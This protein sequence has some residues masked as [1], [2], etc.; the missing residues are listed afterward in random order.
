[1]E[2]SRLARMA[3]AAESSIVTCSLA[4]TT[5]MGSD[6]TS[7]CWAS[8]RR[9]TSSRPTRM[10]FTPRVL[11]ARIAPSISG[12]GAWSVPMASTAIVTIMAVRLQQALT[13]GHFDNVTSMILSAMRTDAVGQAIFVTGGALGGGGLLQ[14]V[15]ST[16]LSPARLRV[17][18]FR[19]RHSSLFGPS[20]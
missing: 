14:V 3:L 12:L 7:S 11:A 2:L 10:T 15:V 5:S 17:S 1:M 20:V 18:S 4:W 8:S 16:A 19:I 13:F 9:I 6:L